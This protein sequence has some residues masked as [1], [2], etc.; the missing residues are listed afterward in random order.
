[1]ATL[2]NS[3]LNIDLIAGSSD[4][5][6]TTTTNVSLTPFENFLI[7]SGG[8]RFLLKCTLFG[9]DSGFNGSDDELFIFPSQ[10]VVTEGTFT[11]R[12]RVSRATLNEDSVGNDEVF[13]RFNLQS[14]EQIFP[15]SQEDR[16][17][18]ISGDF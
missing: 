16:S 13:A 10:T 18:T 5:D 4:T 3:T 15:F 17:P 2:S 1:M 8:L 7:N 14:T 6:V 12:S 11:F 9:E